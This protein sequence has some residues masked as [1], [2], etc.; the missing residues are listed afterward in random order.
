MRFLREGERQNRQKKED[1]SL[2]TSGE[3][4]LREWD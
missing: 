4:A 1:V 2:R 3:D